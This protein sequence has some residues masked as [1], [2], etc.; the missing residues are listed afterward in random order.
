MSTYNCWGSLNVCT[1]DGRLAS[2][3]VPELE[4]YI[5]Q[6]FGDYS[7]IMWGMDSCSGGAEGEIVELVTALSVAFP[8][9][10]FQIEQNCSD[11]GA[12]IMHNF[13]D[14]EHEA[15]VA[16]LVYP[17]AVRV[18]FPPDDNAAAP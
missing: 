3:H 18:P 11:Y 13:H 15:L 4:N 2:S 1:A 17:K 14:G 10:C 16:E 7:H 12:H 6:H 5:N 8:A 9:L